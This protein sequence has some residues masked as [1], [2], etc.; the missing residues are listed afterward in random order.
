MLLFDEASENDNCVRQHVAPALILFRTPDYNSCRDTTQ[1]KQVQFDQSCGGAEERRLHATTGTIELSNGQSNEHLSGRCIE[2][3]FKE[4]E[5]RQEAEWEKSLA[6]RPG[7]VFGNQ[8]SELVAN[9][10]TCCECG[11]HCQCIVNV[12]STITRRTT[13]TC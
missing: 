6:K 5:V 13:C 12:R 9:D 8:D 4:K 3:P 2:Q 11:K 7:Q 10:T 1:H